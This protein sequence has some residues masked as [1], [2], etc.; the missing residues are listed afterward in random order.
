MTIINDKI[1]FN[2]IIFPIFLPLIYGITL[3]SFPSLENFLIFITILLL[4][5]PHFGATWPI[6]FDKKNINF[7]SEN[8]NIYIYGSLFIILFCLLGFFLFKNFFFLIF[9]AANI[10]H[11]TRQSFG[12]SKLYS[13]SKEQLKFQELTIYIFNF[14]FFLIGLF[15]FYFPIITNEMVLTL[16]LVCLFLILIFALFE[17]KKY[18]ISKSNFTTMTGCLIFFPICFVENPVHA[19]LMGVT[20]HYSQYIILT[21]KVNAG[22]NNVFGDKYNLKDIFLLKFVLVISF[23]GIV[24]AVLSLFSKHND[25][26]LNT[27]FLIPIIGQ[28]LHFYLDSFIWKFSE[29]HN[30]EIT[31]KY[32][33]K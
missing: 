25:E 15:R 10:F 3:F 4:A 5:E 19:I 18:N 12:I 21:A 9:Y 26:F 23:Y 17:Y 29:K 24:M 6:I 22:R 27:L 11:V 16:T 28:M 14:L 2:F 30:R 1:D 20:M 31:L 7:L 32:L 33:V 13:N 8:K